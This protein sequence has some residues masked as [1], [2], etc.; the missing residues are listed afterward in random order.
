MDAKK[1]AEAIYAIY[2]AAQK[3]AHGQ[4][5]WDGFYVLVVH[6]LQA[7]EAAERERC[8]KVAEAVGARWAAVHSVAPVA[9]AEVAAAIRSAP[10]VIEYPPKD[11][12]SFNDLHGLGYCEDCGKPV[13]VIEH[14]ESA[15]TWKPIQNCGLCRHAPCE[16]WRHVQK[17]HLPSCEDQHINPWLCACP[18]KPKEAE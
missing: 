8:A 4:E 13:D 1:Q 11:W 15:E 6:H 9:V 14:P 10:C 18:L 5:G 16:E 7:A 17:D 3:L 12:H 2:K